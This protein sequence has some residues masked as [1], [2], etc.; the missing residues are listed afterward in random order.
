MKRYYSIRLSAGLLV[1]FVGAVLFLVCVVLGANHAANTASAALYTGPTVVLDAGHGGEDGGAVG[2]N[3][4]L[5]KDINLAIALAVRECLVES[6]VP[7]HHLFP[8]D[9]PVRADPGSV[10]SWADAGIFGSRGGHR[11]AHLSE[12]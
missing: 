10:V 7:V 1:F 4:A 5:E 8:P 11:L 9:R 6:G 3:G 12:V 2:A